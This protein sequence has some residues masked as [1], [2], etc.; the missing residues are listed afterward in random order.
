MAIQV[1]D[2]GAVR[3]FLSRG[4]DLN[5]KNGVSNISPLQWASM[6]PDKAINDLVRSSVN[7]PT[8]DEQTAKFALPG[9]PW[10]E[11]DEIPVQ[12]WGTYGMMGC[13]FV[14][15]LSR[16]R[17]ETYYSGKASEK[18]QVYS[19]IFVSGN[20]VRMDSDGGFS[21]INALE[22]WGIRRIA[23]VTMYDKIDINTP[24]QGNFGRCN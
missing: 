5:S 7:A 2:I 16:D 17:S 10:H 1:D 13:D 24:D 19:R 21:A 14:I 15:K 4:I 9:Q 18:P 12:M 23:S 22:P 3:Q 11:T 20:R 8:L 6:A